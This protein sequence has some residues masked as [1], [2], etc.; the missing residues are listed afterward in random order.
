M[1]LSVSGALGSS[2]QIIRF[3]TPFLVLLGLIIGQ[4]L[5]LLF[6]AFEA[7]IIVF[8]TPAIFYCFHE[9]ITNYLEGVL[10]V[11]FLVS[12]LFDL[13]VLLKFTDILSSY[14]V[15]ALRS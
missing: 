12:I 8:A 14:A 2:M 15:G 11:R 7:S 6:D 9:L 5:A 13:A 3:I 4:P 10:L 1:E